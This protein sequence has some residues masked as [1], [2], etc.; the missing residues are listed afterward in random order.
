MR[1]ERS[2][3]LSTHVWFFL[4]IVFINQLDGGAVPIMVSS[5]IRTYDLA[6]M[7]SS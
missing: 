7:G 4:V 3:I 6:T 1:E 2:S 5:I